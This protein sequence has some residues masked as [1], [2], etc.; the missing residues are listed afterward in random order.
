MENEGYEDNSSIW[1]IWNTPKSLEKDQRNCV[2]YR[3]GEIYFWQVVY[4][5]TDPSTRENAR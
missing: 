1:S 5:F 3:I 2:T 4:I